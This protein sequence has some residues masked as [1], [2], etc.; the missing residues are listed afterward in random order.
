MRREIAGRVGGI[1]GWPTDGFSPSTGLHVF[2]PRLLQAC[3]LHSPA[4]THRKERYEHYEELRDFCCRPGL[5]ADGDL[6]Y[7]DRT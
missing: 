7:L 5:T 4:I 1:V 3:G 6:S 2:H